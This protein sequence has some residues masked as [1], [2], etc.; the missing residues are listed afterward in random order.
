MRTRFSILLVAAIVLGVFELAR[1]SHAQAHHLTCN[2]LMPIEV[3]SC[4]VYQ[5]WACSG[6]GDAACGCPCW[7]NL[8]TCCHSGEG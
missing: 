7:S 5:G 1:P 4:I 2:H 3:D 8:A 6:E